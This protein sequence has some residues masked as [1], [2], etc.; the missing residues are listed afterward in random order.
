VELQ[1]TGRIFG[2]LFLGTFVTSI[3]ARLLF[4]EGLGASWEDMR[5]VAGAG[6]ETSLKVGAILEFGVI[7]FN[8][9]TA[10]V[11][12]PLVR[13]QS[14]TVSLGYVTARIMESTFI[15][16]GLISII[17]V[18]GVMDALAGASGAQATALAVEG[19]SLVDMY[20]WA[21]LFGPGLVVGFGNGLMLGYLMYRSALVPRRMAMLGLVGGPL[22]ILSFVLQ[23]FDVYET[24]SGAAFLLALPEIAWELSLGIYAAWKGFRTSSPLA[25]P[26]V[27]MAG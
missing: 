17:S 1:R 5:F 9:A 23:L 12:Y 20:E 26:D 3:P 19:D 2:W 15:A 14:E 4:V 16:V 7:A 18:V 13:R 11:I 22:L 10:V 8:I 25:A 27:A 21:F 6:S 24:G